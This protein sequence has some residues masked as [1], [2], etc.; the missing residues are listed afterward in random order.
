MSV[1]KTQFLI[2]A[3]YDYNYGGCDIYVARIS[4]CNVGLCNIKLIKYF[5]VFHFFSYICNVLFR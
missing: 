1:V 5:P 3:A 4:S 2:G